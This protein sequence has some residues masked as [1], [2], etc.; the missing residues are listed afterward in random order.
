MNRR[1]NQQ[2]E[3]RRP[4]VWRHIRRRRERRRRRPARRHDRGRGARRRPSV[5]G[6]RR[7]RQHDQRRPYRRQPGGRVSAGPAG[8]K[9]TVGRWAGG[10]S[11][12]VIRAL[13]G[14]PTNRRRPGNLPGSGYA[15]RADR[16]AWRAGDTRSA[17]ANDGIH[18]RPRPGRRVPH[19]RARPARRRM[20]AEQAA[21]VLPWHWTL[22]HAGRPRTGRRADRLGPGRPPGAGDRITSRATDAGRR[23]TRIQQRGP[24][25]APHPRG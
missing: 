12:R 6:R 5:A 10:R 18:T 21:R 4:G 22:P 15:P 17:I 20:L 3:Q 11:R 13:V 23:R 19:G 1:G 16:P 25:V 24:V 8:G 9:L 7:P 14:S 2:V